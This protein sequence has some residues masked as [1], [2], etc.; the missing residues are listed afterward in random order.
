MK[1]P[2]WGLETGSY[3][4]VTSKAAVTS[5]G[6]TSKSTA[7]DLIPGVARSVI[8]AN[9]RRRVVAPH[10]SAV[11]LPYKMSPMPAVVSRVGWIAVSAG[12]DAAL[13][14][15]LVARQAPRRSYFRRHIRFSSAAVACAPE[16]TS[17]HFAKGLPPQNAHARRM[18]DARDL[19]TAAA[20]VRDK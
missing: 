13:G 9:D 20:Q 10:G 3:T 15:M 5:A 16:S 6:V 11:S 14:V 4:G 7:I 2:S 8:A 1:R 17:I 12:A 18:H 19:S